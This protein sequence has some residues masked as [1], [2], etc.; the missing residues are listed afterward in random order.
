[1]EHVDDAIAPGA[2][3]W[4]TIM[5]GV[6]ARR[7]PTEGMGRWLERQEYLSLLREER[8]LITANDN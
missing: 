3:Y 6:G 4:E 5:H 1:M 8:E 7:K 2:E